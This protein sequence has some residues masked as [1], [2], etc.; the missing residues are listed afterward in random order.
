MSLLTSTILQE[1]LAPPSRISTADLIQK[2]VLPSTLS[3]FES[4]PLLASST[5]NNSDPTTT[6]TELGV[7]FLQYNNKATRGAT[8][9]EKSRQFRGIY[10]NHGFGASSL[11]WLPVL[12]K[13]VARLGARVG[14]AHDAV[15]FGFTDRPSPHQSQRKKSSSNSNHAENGGTDDALAF[16]TTRGSSQ[17]GSALL[18]RIILPETSMDSSSPDSGTT[19]NDNN[20]NTEERD[21]PIILMGHSLGALTTLQMAL[22]LPKK[23]RKWVILVAPALGIRNKSHTK[24]K[25]A[26]NANNNKNGFGRR[27]HEGF[28]RG[29]SL[30][31]RYALRRVVGYVSFVESFLVSGESIRDR[32]GR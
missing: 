31:G 23:T 11:S 7:H 22:A 29:A 5:N 18:Q 19:T 27:I 32:T 3:K 14:V 1:F 15:G 9:A 12:P 24:S 16:Y 25:A 26:G 13:L 30:V 28:F 17:I 20:V 2:Y 21:N 10:C 4:V 8:F 6:T